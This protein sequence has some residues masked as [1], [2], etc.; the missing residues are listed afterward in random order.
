MRNP[1]ISGIEYQQG[2]LQGYEI[3]EYLLEKFN[4]T[5]VYCKQKDVPLEVEHI[6]PKTRGGTDR[7]DNLAI[8][9]K[10]C[11]RKKGKMTAEEFGFPDVQKQ[12]KK[13]LKDAAIVN[14]TR[15]AILE[16][17]QKTGLPVECG[18]GARTKMNRIKQGLPK[19]HYFDACCVGA[20]TPDKLI[21]CTKQVQIIE[22]TGRGKRQIINVDRY[23]FPRGYFSRNKMYFGFQTGD[24]VK[25]NVSRGKNVGKHT[26]R[27]T[28]RARGD[29]AIKNKTGFDR[30]D[31][32]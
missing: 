23:G 5:C 26:G 13:T 18:T 29:F 14:A 30:R 4:W 27:V 20:S 6:I 8:S 24:I 31:S 7:I 1:E 17:L 15:L 2:T 16:A 9:C 32:S 21:F 12:V 25:A 3:R 11:N 19:E 10:D 28:C 22:A